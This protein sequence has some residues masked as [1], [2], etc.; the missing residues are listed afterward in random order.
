M[1]KILKFLPGLT[2]A[3]CAYMVLKLITWTGLTYEFAAFLII[4]LLTTILMDSAM[5]SYGK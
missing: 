3:V 2:G 5:R 1:K 4:Y